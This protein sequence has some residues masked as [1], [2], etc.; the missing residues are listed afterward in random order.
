MRLPR[1]T[2][3]RC[4]LFAALSLFV[5][6][7]TATAGCPGADER[8]LQWLDKMSHSLREVSYQ[9]VVT[10][11]RGSEMRVMEVSHKVGQ[12]GSHETL[13]ELTGS[14]ARVERKTHPLECV[15][16][17]IKLLRAGL[18]DRCGIAAQYRLGVTEGDRVAG[19]NAVS[20]LIEPRDVY[21]F[22]YVMTLDRDTG[23]L[24]KAQTITHGRKTL[25]TMQFAQLSYT[26]PMPVAG[27]SAVIHEALHP[28]MEA[29]AGGG[30]S[31]G[32]AWAVGWL[33][34]GFT[35]T[36]ATLGTGGRRTYT[37]GLAVFS[38]FLEDLDQEIQPGEGAVNKGGTTT[39]TR[40]LRLGGRPVLVTVIG[41]VPVNTARMVADSVRW[42]Q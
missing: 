40:G 5:G 2:S 28:S 31:V 13:T 11:Q 25:E 12:D 37:D 30:E 9:G 15:H 6:V 1:K 36:D 16:P 27:G 32:R 26:E 14:G 17:G 33:P 20:I 4:C 41:E 21:R 23:L 35:A 10:L 34:S 7:G 3:E 39:Y 24:L 19:R 38:I 42:E 29:I 8:A 22:G 18:A